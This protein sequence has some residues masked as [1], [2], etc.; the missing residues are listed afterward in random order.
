MYGSSDSQSDRTSTSPGPGLGISL[1]TSSKSDSCGMPT[2]RAAS[3]ICLFTRWL[4]GNWGACRSTIQ[5]V[6]FSQS[7]DFIRA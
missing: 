3:V 6:T 1:S 7:R 5:A 2:G 4:I